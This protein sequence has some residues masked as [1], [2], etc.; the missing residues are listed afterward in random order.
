MVEVLSVT[1]LL[2]LHCK[3]LQTNSCYEISCMLVYSC[4]STNILICEFVKY[5]L[6]LLQ[7]KFTLSTRD[8]CVI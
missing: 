1:E 7:I 5:Y 3:P 8:I 4:R 6:H 2:H